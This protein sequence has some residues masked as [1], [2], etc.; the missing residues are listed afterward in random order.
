LET[1]YQAVHPGAISFRG[2]HDRSLAEIITPMSEYNW[3][4]N[5]IEFMRGGCLDD[6]LEAELVLICGENE[7]RFVL[8]LA[9]QLDSIRFRMG[10]NLACKTIAHGGLEQSDEL[11]YLVRKESAVYSPNKLYLVAHPRS[12]SKQQREGLDRFM[13]FL[14]EQ[15]LLFHMVEVDPEV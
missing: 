2:G 7:R 8:E 9:Q 12:K 6:V 15:R 13:Q 14:I 3:T 11:I 1:N 10:L 5:W 4:N